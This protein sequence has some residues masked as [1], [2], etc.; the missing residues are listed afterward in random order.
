MPNNLQKIAEDSA[1]GS[2]FLIAGS[3]TATIISAIAAIIVARLIGPPLY[4]QYTLSLTISQ[5]LFLFTNLGID[6]GL[7]Q[8]KSKPFRFNPL[9]ST[10]LQYNI[11]TETFY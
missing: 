10:L 1:R 9:P 3:I 7:T 11:L 5:M 4:G 6:Q 8:N 2:V